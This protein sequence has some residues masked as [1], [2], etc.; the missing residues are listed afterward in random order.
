MLW[1]LEWFNWNTFLFIMVHSSLMECTWPNFNHPVA[2]STV[3]IILTI[4]GNQYSTN[5]DYRR[6]NGT[7][8]Q[9][10]DPLLVKYMC[11]AFSKNMKIVI[12]VGSSFSFEI[13]ILL[14]FVFATKLFPHK[15]CIK[16]LKR[17]MTSQL[18]QL[19][20]LLLVTLRKRKW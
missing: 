3:Q 4:G 20:I 1:T 8:R 10:N 18:L 12:F 6:L 11:H 13:K 9:M 14:D 17:Y 7:V 16:H 2:S 19:Y 15:K 5:T